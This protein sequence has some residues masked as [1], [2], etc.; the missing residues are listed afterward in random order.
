MSDQIVK[1]E[2]DSSALEKVLING[3]LSQLTPQE[4]VNFY[5]KTC[6]TLGLNPL[7][8][9]FD[10]IRLNN[11]LV[12]YPKRDCT[13]QLR[14]I[15][16]ISITKLDR[17]KMDDVYVVTA[18]GCNQ[19]GREDSSTGVV[20]IAGLRGDALANAMMKAET[21]AKRRLTLSL[22]GLGF[23]DESEIETIKGAEPVTV[24][25]D[26]EIIDGEVEHDLEW[27]QNYTT[28]KGTRL[29]DLNL[30]QL[31]E[32]EQYTMKGD[33]FEAYKLVRNNAEAIENMK[34]TSIDDVKG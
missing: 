8:K 18:Y 27:A 23:T 22:S 16:K 17:D 10:Y 7:T 5:M 6:E 32:L 2:V 3:D 11:K 20:S 26:G 28:K 34:D 24:S 12:L 30:D 21:K 1:Y 25:D 29:G 4:R 31:I 19:E 9:P 33:L 15:H 14:N 13:D